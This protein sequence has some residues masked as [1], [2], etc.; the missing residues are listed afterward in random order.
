MSCWLRVACRLALAL[1]GVAHAE[2]WDRFPELMGLMALVALGALV[3]FVLLWW[4]TSKIPNALLRALIRGSALVA[5]LWANG[6][7][8]GPGTLS[9][10]FAWP[11][12][13]FAMGFAE[14]QIV[15][16]QKSRAGR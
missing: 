9:P 12:A 5:M 2:G 11:L 4:L 15:L 3:A 13:V 10:F 16:K 7:F 6:R 14:F 8:E 1:P